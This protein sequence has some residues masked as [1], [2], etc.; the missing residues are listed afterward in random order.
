MRSF[1]LV[2]LAALFSAVLAL[3]PI[4]PPVGKPP[5]PK[6][7]AL[8]SNLLVASPPGNA[9][10]IYPR[11]VELSDGT[12]LVTVSGFGLNP[13]VF[14]VYKSTDFGKTW[15]LFSNITDQVNGWGMS[16]QPFLYELPCRF[17]GFP[18]GTVLAT[19]NSWS[20]NG[21]SIDLYASID[22]GK[23]WKF[24]SNVAKGGP[25]STENGKTPVWEPAI[26][27]YK[28]QLVVYYSDQRDKLHG[29]KLAHQTSKD[30]KKW[31]PVVND[32]AYA[33]YTARPGMTVVAELPNKKWIL[34]HEFPFSGKTETVEYPVYYRIADSPLEFDKAKGIPIIVNGT[35]PNASPYV[36]WTSAGGKDGTI[37]VS[38][39]DHTGVFTNKK[40]GDPKAWEYHG[41][42]QP[43]SYSRYLHV[44]SKFPNR[45]A[46]IGAGKY[47]DPR[48][49]F[50]I[51]VVDVEKLLRN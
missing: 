11:A 12:L 17:G 7:P 18:E 24:V 6:E 10:Y 48:Q 51:S 4:I 9:A 2:C 40:L 49:N 45:L 50:T 29:Q 22:K 38:D 33:N 42:P 26:L 21:T 28:E 44:F 1:S 43:D 5:L 14:P 16:A 47:N 15:K 32:V 35:Q 19:G 25:P 8:L 13:A 36:V 39:A 20:N 34:V 31:G 23:T 46:I 3:P 41:T 30:L 27:F 37:I